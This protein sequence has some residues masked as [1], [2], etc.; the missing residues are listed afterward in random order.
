MNLRQEDDEY[1]NQ[2]L[3]EK[4]HRSAADGNDL[5]KKVLQRKMIRDQIDT[6][7]DAH[8]DAVLDNDIDEYVTHALTHAK[9]DIPLQQ[10][11]DKHNITFTALA[12]LIGQYGY[13]LIKYYII[14]GKID[15]NGHTYRYPRW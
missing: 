5:A 9:K 8:F 10:A 14:T 11:M 13:L 1:T 6:D 12:D 2:L 15:I 7:S 4:L 3:T